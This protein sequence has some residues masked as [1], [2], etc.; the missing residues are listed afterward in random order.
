MAKREKIDLDRFD[1]FDLEDNWGM[2]REPTPARDG[3]GKREAV[4]KAGKTVLREMGKTTFTTQMAKTILKEAMPRSFTTTLDNIDRG[5]IDTRALYAEVRRDASPMVREM[6][7]LG[8]TVNRLVPTPYQKKIDA[9]LSRQSATDNSG[10][11]LAALNIEDA[12]VLQSL[13]QVFNQEESKTKQESTD[14]LTEKLTDQKYKVKLGTAI[15]SIQN[16]LAKQTAYQFGAQRAFQKKSMELQIR[17][18]M[19]SRAHLDVAQKSAIETSNLLRSIVENSALPDVVKQHRSEEFMRMGREKIFGR[20]QSSMY[21]WTSNY[22]QQFKDRVKQVVGDRVQKFQTGMGLANST[23]EQLEMQ[24]E[25]L[26]SMGVTPEEFLGG[27]AGNWGAL[28]IGKRIGR[29]INRR[30]PA[31]RRLDGTFQGANYL[32]N[33]KERLAADWG[34]SGYRYGKWYN[35]IEN[36][37]KDTLR[38]GYKDGGVV[39]A[40][41]LG[42]GD[43][44]SSV[45][46][47]KLGYMEEMSGY[48]SRILHSIDVLRTGDSK[49]PRTVFNRQKGIFTTFDESVAS[50]REALL[51]DTDIN[52][53]RENVERLITSI[54]GNNRL[55]PQARGKISDHLMARARTSKAFNPGQ[56]ANEKINGLSRDEMR[57]W[58]G[59][60]AKRYGLKLNEKSEWTLNP[61]SSSNVNLNIDAGQYNHASNQTQ[62]IFNRAHGLAQTGNLEE[63]ISEGAVIFKNGNWEL[64]P[65]YYGNRVGGKRSG[66]NNPPSNPGDMGPPRPGDRPPVPPTPDGNPPD[67]RRFGQDWTNPNSVNFNLGGSQFASVLT[68]QTDRILERMEKSQLFWD[69]QMARIESQ[70]AGLGSA[71]TGGGDG[72]GQPPGPGPRRRFSRGWVGRGLRSGLRGAGRGVKGLWDLG[73]LPFK[74]AGEVFRRIRRPAFNA[75]MTIGTFGLNKVFGY[76]MQ[77]FEKAQDGYITTVNGLKKVLTKEGLESGQYIDQATGKVIKKLSD[78]RGAVWDVVNNT[79]VISDDEAKGGLFN[80]AGTRVKTAFSKT[81]GAIGSLING[82]FTPYNLMKGAL[83]LGGKGLG[84][85]LTRLP[86]IYVKGESKP[87][88]YA[89]KLANGEYFSMR[90]GKRISKLSDIDGDVGT[91]DPRT[92]TMTPIMTAEDAAK[93][94]VDRNGQA[95][96]TGLGRLVGMLG[97]GLRG[98]FNFAASP[99]KLLNAMGRTAANIATSG[100]RTVGNIFT[101]GAFGGRSMGTGSNTWLKRIYRLLVNQFTGKNPLDGLEEAEGGLG[102][103]KNRLTGGFERL[104]NRAG[105]WWSRLQKKK[106]DEAKPEHAERAAKES[107]GW[108]KLIWAAITGVG[109]IV[110]KVASGFGSFW[111]WIKELPRWIG[112]SKAA[113]AAGDLA[114]DALDGAGRRRGGLLRRAGGVLKK[115]GKGALGVAGFLGRGLFSGAGMLARGAAMAAGSLLSAPVLIGAAV[116]VGVGYLIYKGYQAYKNKLTLL[117]KY[118]VAQYGVNPKDDDKAGKVL[119]LEEAVLKSSQIDGQGKLKIGSLPFQDL[120][121]AFGIEITDQRAVQRWVR[122]YQMRFVPVFSRNVEILHQMDPKAKITDAEFLKDSQRGDFAR[123][124]FIASGGAQSPYLVSDSPFPEISS[125]TGDRFV[126]GWRDQV[127]AEY[128]KAEKAAAASGEK[129]VL[130]VGEAK[131]PRGLDALN[132]KAQ[133]MQAANANRNINPSTDLYYSPGDTRKGMTSLTGDS[134]KDE[135]IEIGNRIDDLTSIRMKLYGLPELVKGDVNTL[136]ALEAE[137]I[138]QVRY[139]DKGVA[140]WT[141]NAEQFFANWNG[142]F[143]VNANSPD[144]KTGWLFWFNKRFLPVFLNFCSESNYLSPNT[145]PLQAWKKLN[146]SDLL[147]IANFM[148]G[149]TTEVNGNRVSVWTIKAS[150][151]PNRISNLD[152]SVIQSNLD[153]LRLESKK[154]IYQEKVKTETEIS[155]MTF[156]GKPLRATVT[157]NKIADLMTDVSAITAAGKGRATGKN[158]VGIYGQ[159]LG[160]MGT[161]YERAES[162]SSF[163]DTNLLHSGEGTGGSI[164]DIPEPKGDG[165][166]NVKDSLVA[167]AKMVGVDPGSLAAMIA[168][169]SGFELRAKNG[170][171]S[172]AGLGQFIDGTWKEMLPILVKKYGVNP[173]TS[174]YDPRASL[175]ATAEYMKKNAAIIGDIGRPLTTTDIYMAHFLGPGGARKVLKVPSNTPIATAM[176]DQYASAAKANKE[177]FNGVRTTGDLVASLGRYLSNNGGRY[178][179]EANAMANKAGPA[180]PNSTDSGAVTNVT[181]STT[182]P[183]SDNGTAETPAVVASAKS[184]ANN[185]AKG[186]LPTGNTTS[187]AVVNRGTDTLTP[188]VTRATDKRDETAIVQQSVQRDKAAAASRAAVAAAR[189]QTAQTTSETN[190]WANVLNDQLAVQKSMDSTLIEIKELIQKGG[191]LGGNGSSDNS[192]KASPN[193]DELKGKSLNVNGNGPRPYEPFD[194]SLSSQYR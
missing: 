139:G 45:D 83:G 121:T 187:A 30:A 180:V 79:Q 185:P 192:P 155:Q 136:V 131:K 182:T 98:A 104:K 21:D 194:T 74:A 141:G 6:K 145:S 25:L 54:D 52:A 193:T 133:Q 148:N 105:S 175:L 32:F 64:N 56:I 20:I 130:A 140:Y 144:E 168:Q 10:K 9:Y 58:Q 160:S 129:K 99:F 124:T 93:G 157:G 150:P 78:V 169:E 125:V 41:G 67:L 103:I 59:L 102:G 127:I 53:Q 156:A 87:R 90:T 11:Q 161:S 48:L 13:A 101:G 57:L 158:G 61:F 142:Q 181:P 18:L 143:A 95:I 174:Q 8:R 7:V 151:W 80:A 1:D 12:A 189:Q 86:D 51:K 37:L 110:S 44:I 88:L 184:V 108:G 42:N 190:G 36:F 92:R 81:V 152:S 115:V 4:K 2:D 173:N 31:L 39:R 62:G 17:Q 176:G 149:A 40:G 118:R 117:R 112:A 120:V 68:A 135:L 114:G 153:A 73:G 63:L 162:G 16:L 14:E 77:A 84:S 167:V 55:S 33:N 163:T 100:I 34:N 29:S 126:A 27:A 106:P 188:A 19:V 138:K 15:A 5:L 119:A 28:Q 111:K 172:A 177:I 70:L 65:E 107:G 123:S 166:D 96:R 183:T 69:E 132:Q 170:S 113:G 60:L 85:L 75:A 171:S 186:E 3:S 24:R 154:E 134:R 91:L 116:A 97:S 109:A 26:A 159:R 94:L 179:Q 178:I 50:T 47:R 137:A 66:S 82:R 72:S 46:E 38:G 76:G 122:W 49:A 128:A 71:G 164:N 43:K 147:K 23:L 191:L 89:S 35:P 22:R 165:W 146:A